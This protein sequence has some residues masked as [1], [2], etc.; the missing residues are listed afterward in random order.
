MLDN[1]NVFIWIFLIAMVL[2]LIIYG[3]FAIR[4]YSFEKVF[5]IPKEK[6]MKSVKS[7]FATTK[8]RIITVFVCVCLLIV[9]RPIL[10]RFLIYVKM[11]LFRNSEQGIEQAPEY[12]AWTMSYA[13]E[14][15]GETINLFANT[16]KY[17]SSVIIRMLGENLGGHVL[18]IPMP[19]LALEGILVVIIL[20]ILYH[21]GQGLN[22]KKI[23]ICFVTFS[24]V[25][26]AI[27]IGCMV[28]FTA[29][30]ASS[31]DV[32]V[33]YYLPLF[34]CVLIA[35]GT[36]KVE[37]EETLFLFTIQHI[38]MIVIC[39]NMFVSMYGI[40]SATELGLM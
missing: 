1:C 25:L 21:R 39:M 5:L 22:K 34:S 27:L 20:Q 13:S 33:R 28:R 10:G 31:I 2:P 37:T 26:F 35:C 15:I 29:V 30:G 38:L 9:G 17:S 40:E 8:S 11:S 14:H 4:G 23:I 16:L 7:F 19:V 18:N 36:N 24:I 12:M 6:V 32:S 3:Y